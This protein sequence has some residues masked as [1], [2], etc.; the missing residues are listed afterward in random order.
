MAGFWNELRRKLPPW[1][2]L[3]GAT[4][5]VKT[6]FYLVPVA[7]I[8]GLA[9]WRAEVSAPWWALALAVL[10]VG[11]FAF[12]FG[13]AWESSSRPTVEIEPIQ[14]DH[15][16][17]LFFVWVQNGAVPIYFSIRVS[18]L[19][20][21]PWKG[22]YRGEPTDFNERIEAGV[23]VQ[24]GLFT[25]REHE[26]ENGHPMFCIYSCEDTTKP[27]TGKHTIVRILGGVPIEEQ[28]RVEVEAIATFREA[29]ARDADEK[30][31]ETKTAVQIKRLRFEVIPDSTSPAGYLV[32][33]ILP[34]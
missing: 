2:L 20:E 30:A 15:G 26:N 5:V 13:A 34:A 17:K 7:S 29:V 33:E 19:T 3:E 24:Y 21:R 27:P 22:H 10:V 1:S 14:F 12:V 6:L 31:E 4:K 28:E 18:G 9:L 25:V 11:Y 23:R 8:A 32:R 16:L